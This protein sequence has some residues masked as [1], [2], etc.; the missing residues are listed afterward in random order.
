MGYIL[1]HIC[2]IYELDYILS[3]MD[4]I[5]FP[6]SISL[7]LDNSHNQTLLPSFDL[8][9]PSPIFN[10]LVC[11]YVSLHSKLSLVKCLLLVSDEL[12]RCHLINVRYGVGD[13]CVKREL[14]TFLRTALGGGSLVIRRP[15]IL[16]RGCSAE[17]FRCGMID[18][19]DALQE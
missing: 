9:E 1:P 5:G 16:D 12:R 14:L 15:N 3:T 18:Y 17:K 8:L 7:N 10:L 13:T 19:D 2:I 6:C 11:M 4:R